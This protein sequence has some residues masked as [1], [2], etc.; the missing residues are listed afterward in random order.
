MGPFVL[1]LEFSEVT[2][3]IFI[4]KQE[5]RGGQLGVRKTL[6]AA[7]YPQARCACPTLPLRNVLCQLPLIL[8][9]HCLVRGS[10]SVA[11]WVGREQLAANPRR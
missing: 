1:A 5:R 11:C 8:Q 4:E 6:H 9:Q 2:G 7:G 10:V 3:T